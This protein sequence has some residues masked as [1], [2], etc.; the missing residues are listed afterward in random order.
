[1]L[2]QPLVHPLGNLNVILLHEEHVS[3]AVDPFLAQIR[4]LHVDTHLPQVLDGAVVVGRVERRLARDDELG[5]ARKVGQLP[6]GTRLHDALVVVGVHGRPDA[7][8]DVLGVRAGGRAVADGQVRQAKRKGR[9]GAKGRPQRKGRPGGL[10][11]DDALDEV[12]AHVADS[13]AFFFY[14][15]SHFGGGGIMPG[16]AGESTY[17]MRQLANG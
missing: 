13:P 3:V 15:Q 1:M 6:D 11:L 10:E 7:R 12:G 2:L 5:D 9:V 17:H 4:M 16:S 14:H 8:L